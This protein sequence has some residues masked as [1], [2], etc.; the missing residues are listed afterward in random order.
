MAVTSYGLNSSETV[1][2]WSR[3]LF[4]E[5][6]KQTWLHKFM[7]EGTD[8]I[9]QYVNDLAKGP[10][11]RVTNILRMQLSGDGIEGDATLE[12]SEEALTTYTDNFVINQLRHR[13]EE[14]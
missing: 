6:L 14:H 2:V 3:K 1:K 9:I 7:G 8:S 13:S 4:R 5:S 12:G 11:D 10:G